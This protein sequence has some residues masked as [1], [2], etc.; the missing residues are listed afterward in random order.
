MIW[1]SFAPTSNQIRMKQVIKELEKDYI[2]DIKMKIEDS[3]KEIK[4]HLKEIE[5]YE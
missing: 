4:T 1:I 5:I 3:M 2:Y